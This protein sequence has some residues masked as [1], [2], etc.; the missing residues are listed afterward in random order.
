V[1][2][3]LDAFKAAAD[4]IISNHREADLAD[5]GDKVMT[6]DLFEVD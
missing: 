5:A 6:R 3:D 1:I 4:Q 2:R